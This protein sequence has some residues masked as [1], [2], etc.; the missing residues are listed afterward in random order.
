MSRNRRRYEVAIN[1]GNE[2][3]A[4]VGSGAS[5][6]Y[7]D[8]VLMSTERGRRLQG[9]VEVETSESVNHLEAM[10]QWARLSRL[11]APFHLYVPAGSVDSARR[12]CVENQISVAEIWT[13]HTIGDQVRFTMV[14]RAPAESRAASRA[15]RSRQPA[16]ARGRKV[17]ARSA[18]AGPARSKKV[19]KPA[20]PARRK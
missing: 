6:M 1:P 10:A 13:Y 16:P 15:Q 9:I 20:R 5:A 17:I 12:F 4:V 2:Q 18:K 11:R 8:L 3:N 19:A 7:P 14:H